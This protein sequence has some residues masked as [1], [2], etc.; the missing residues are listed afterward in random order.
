MIH[1]THVNVETRMVI[2][3]NDTVYPIESFFD[4]RGWEVSIH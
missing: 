4:P 1:I 2:T 3:M